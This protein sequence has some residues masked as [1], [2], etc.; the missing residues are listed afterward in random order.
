MTNEFDDNGK[1]YTDII[2][3]TPIHVVIQTISH[4]IQGVVHIRQGQRLKDELDIQDKFIAITDA[5]ISMPDGQIIGRANF[6]AVQRNVIIWVMPD[7]KAFD[8][9]EE[10]TK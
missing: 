9:P 1:F 6:L 2:S 4:R 7:D 5:I 3:K 10:N 8:L